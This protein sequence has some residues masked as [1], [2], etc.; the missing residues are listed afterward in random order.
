MASRMPLQIHA[1]KDA[2]AKTGDRNGSYHHVNVDNLIPRHRPSPVT[3]SPNAVAIQFSEQLGSRSIQPNRA[4]FRKNVSTS[5]RLA[6]EQSWLAA[7][8][9]PVAMRFL[10]SPRAKGV[11]PPPMEAGR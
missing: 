2:Q 10:M 7:N 5:V 9:L 4:I 6:K 11:M 1:E 3:E 8:G